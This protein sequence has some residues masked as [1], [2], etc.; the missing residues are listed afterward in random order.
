MVVKIAACILFLM[1]V[2]LAI[3]FLKK[4]RDYDQLAEKYETAI[5]GLDEMQKIVEDKTIYLHGEKIL[6]M[7]DRCLR[8]VRAAEPENSFERIFWQEREICLLMIKRYLLEL[9][10]EQTNNGI[11]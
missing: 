9:I 8:A 10:K 7:L 3:I 4:S 11:R 1:V 6:E 5:E 2:F